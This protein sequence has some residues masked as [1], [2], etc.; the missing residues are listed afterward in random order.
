[1]TLE[2]NLHVFTLKSLLYSEY[3]KQANS[4]D[5]C[6][7]FYSDLKNKND[8]ICENYRCSKEELINH[9]VDLFSYED[10]TFDKRLDCVERKCSRNK[11]RS[12][13]NDYEDLCIEAVIL[14]CLNKSGLALT[15]LNI[16]SCA[17]NNKAIIQRECTIEACITNEVNA[18]SEEKCKLKPTKEY[19]EQC[20]EKEK[21]ICTTQVRVRLF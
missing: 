5:D 8:S 11:F 15:D 10:D 19:L 4:V 6:D 16:K 2:K 13:C 12:Q 3:V 21:D 7:K 17:I 14:H 9:C 20:A 1:M 18:C